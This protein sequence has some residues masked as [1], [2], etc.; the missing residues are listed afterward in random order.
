MHVCARV[1][2]TRI[3]QSKLD[4]GGIL[5]MTHLMHIGT[6]FDSFTAAVIE[7][8]LA[9]MR[10]EQHGGPPPEELAVRRRL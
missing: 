9:S 3:E 8:A 6:Y 1:T 5:S 10:W 7:E 4:L 2:A